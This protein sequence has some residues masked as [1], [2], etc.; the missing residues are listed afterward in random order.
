MTSIKEGCV[1]HYKCII[2]YDGTD[3]CG[4]QLQ[5][6]CPTITQELQST[7]FKVFGCEVVIIG[8]SRTDAGVHALGQVALC[9]TGLLID[10]AK[11]MWA[12]NN[13]LC[14]DIVVRSCEY[15][16]RYFHPRKNVLQKTYVY[17]FSCNRPLPD[18]ARYCWYVR[19]KVDMEKLRECLQLFVGTHDFRSFCTGDEMGSD[20]VRTIDSIEI[21]SSGD[22]H[23][24]SIEVK[25]K[26]F[27][28]YMV[29]RMVG[30]SL[31]IASHV[32]IPVE[33]VRVIL[34]AC[35]PEHQLPA[36]PALGLS[37]NLISYCEEKSS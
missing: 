21:R 30:A 6:H 19:R 14:S 16:D 12:W 29:R 26:S 23:M 13:R 31:Y 10:P 37:L 34:Q 36:A 32:H 20:T 3:Y 8:A 9:R 18:K 24:Y 11:L 17:Q 25:G 7:F 22:S 15:A 1:H 33:Y 4:W 35:N 27:L 28:R 2:A 5:P